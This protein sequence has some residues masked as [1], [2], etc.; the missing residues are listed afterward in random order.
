MN[1]SM[2]V[3]TSAK[4]A[5]D[6]SNN[7]NNHVEIHNE[8]VMT[9]STKTDAIDMTAV[10]LRLEREYRHPLQ[11]V[12]PVDVFESEE[13]DIKISL[14]TTIDELVGAHRCVYDSCCRISPTTSYELHG[15]TVNVMDQLNDIEQKSPKLYSTI[16]RCSYNSIHLEASYIKS[17]LNARY[18]DAKLKSDD[19]LN[20]PFA[21]ESNGMYKLSTVGEVMNTLKLTEDDMD[22]YLL[23]YHGYD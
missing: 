18:L 13:G 12:S 9:Q 11:K 4:A 20:A 10:Y 21:Y 2:E 16:M 17:R 14:H 3:S 6:N 1:G 8:D 15:W 5:N 22:I 7:M 23:G 19:P